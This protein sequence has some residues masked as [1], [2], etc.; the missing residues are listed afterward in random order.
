MESGV[1]PGELRF[2]PGVVRVVDVCTKLL[3]GDGNVSDELALCTSPSD[4][5]SATGAEVS[6]PC[7]AV[8]TLGITVFVPALSE[9]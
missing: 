8:S 1:D 2:S 7:G 3:F 4:Q 6:T 9:L 5:R